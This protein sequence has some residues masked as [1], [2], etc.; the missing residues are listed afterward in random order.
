MVAMLARAVAVQL[1]CLAAAKDHG[2]FWESAKQQVRQAQQKV[3]EVLVDNDSAACAPH[4]LMTPDAFT[5]DASCAGPDDVFRVEEIHYEPVARA[6][7]VQG[8][9][10]KEV[11]GGKVVAQVHL[12]KSSAGSGVRSVL[13]RQMAW[14]SSGS[15]RTS[16]PLC[17]HV[18]RAFNRSGIAASCPFSPGPQEFRLAFEQ[19]PKLVAA[20]EYGI[21]IRAADDDHQPI[22]CVSGSINIPRGPGGEL[23]RLLESNAPG[24]RLAACCRGEGTE[25][26]DCRNTWNDGVSDRCDDGRTV[27]D[28]GVCDYAVP[29]DYDGAMYASSAQSQ[30]WAPF[31]IILSV[32]SLLVV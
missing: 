1:C 10:S 4:Q 9:L 26:S 32:A 6:L 20:G 21:E 29:Y 23:F 22:F 14:L 27:R 13:K 7:I 28:A 15:H 31:A 30:T 16:R 3:R 12:R 24:R 2:K 18:T 11:A 5:L 25:C 19:L 8:A 17:D